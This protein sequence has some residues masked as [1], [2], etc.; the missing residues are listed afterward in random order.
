MLDG[1]PRSNN[2]DIK[3]DNNITWFHKCGTNI[4]NNMKVIIPI[5][6]END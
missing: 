3:L 2:D 6:Y 5:K 1:I 4:Q